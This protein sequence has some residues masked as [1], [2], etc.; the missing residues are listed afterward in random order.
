MSAEQPRTVATS[1][2]RSPDH[3]Y[4][5]S[6]EQAAE[7]YAKAGHPR[8]SRA[9]QKYCALS[10]LD[11]HKVE[12]ETGEKYLV[13]PYS[14][15]RHITYINEVRTVATGRDQTR[16]DANVRTMENK[17]AE[18]TNGREQPRT[19]PVVRGPEDRYVVL[20]EKENEFLRGQVSVKDTQ[21]EALLERDKETN[22]LIHRLQAMLA[23]LL[24]APKHK[25]PIE[26]GSPAD[27]TAE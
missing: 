27:E 22:T 24:V 16:T 18:G 2:E 26:R 14:V 1:R 21:I 15:D 7:L 10:K 8:T 9:I 6:I 11:C 4:T 20:L 25:E 23:P 5:L 3:Q 12:T 17:G 13:A 19:D